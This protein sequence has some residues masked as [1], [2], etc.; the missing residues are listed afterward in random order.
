MQVKADGSLE[1]TDKHS[2]RLDPDEFFEGSAELLAQLPGLLMAFIGENL[3]LRLVHE[4]RANV[5]LRDLDFGNKGKNE[6]TQFRY[7]ERVSVFD[8]AAVF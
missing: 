1:S 3:A 8:Q 6:K 2:A 5:P 4:N 7:Y